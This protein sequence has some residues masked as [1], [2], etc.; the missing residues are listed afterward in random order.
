MAIEM[1]MAMKKLAL[2]CM[3]RGCFRFG[4][5]RVVA[6]SAERVA[7]A[8]TLKGKRASAQGPVGL[9]RFCGIYRA[10]GGEAAKAAE[11]GR[12]RPAVEGDEEKEEVFHGKTKFKTKLEHQYG[13][14]L[15]NPPPSGRG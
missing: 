8:D 3:G 13:K 9:Q 11:K 4:R 10:A 1:A 15:R 12:E 14:K 6:L 2:S 7:A 5:D